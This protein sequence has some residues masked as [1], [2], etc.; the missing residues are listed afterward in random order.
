MKNIEAIINE[1]KDAFETKEGNY[2]SEDDDEVSLTRKQF[3]AI[4]KE[5]TRLIQIESILSS[6]NQNLCTLINQLESEFP[7]MKQ[8]I[9][10]YKRG[11]TQFS[12]S[13]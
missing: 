8:A 5:I 12:F 7:E 11:S 4:E 3:G 6:E 1:L 10:N 13:K 2:Q 9:V